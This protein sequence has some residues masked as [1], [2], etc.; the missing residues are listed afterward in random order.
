MNAN[1]TASHTLHTNGGLDKSYNDEKD[2]EKVKT[3]AKP[4]VTTNSFRSNDRIT[5]SPKKNPF[6][7]RKSISK[8][9]SKD[10]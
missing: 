8:I 7:R 4:E 5:K 10:I 2:R 3:E 6:W 9:S 1:L